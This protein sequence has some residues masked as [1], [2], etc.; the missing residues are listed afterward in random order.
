MLRSASVVTCTTAGK[1]YSW[2]VADPM[3]AADVPVLAWLPSV[4]PRMHVL[5][6]LFI[7]L[8]AHPKTEGAHSLAERNVTL[9]CYL[10]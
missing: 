5:T 10:M 7:A 6:H 3:V 9:T 1:S 8:S 4:K 2:N